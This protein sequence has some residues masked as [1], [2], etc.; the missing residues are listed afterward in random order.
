M[1]SSSSHH[2]QQHIGESTASGGVVPHGGDK[3]V[4]AADAKVQSMYYD[5]LNYKDSSKIRGVVDVENAERFQEELQ[6]LYQRELEKEREA[7]L[8]KEDKWDNTQHDQQ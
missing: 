3:S 7:K 6:T 5:I 8:G 4:A 1:S 2:Q